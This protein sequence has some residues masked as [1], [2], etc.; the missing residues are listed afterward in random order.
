MAQEPGRH[1]AE[2]RRCDPRRRTGP[3]DFV[4]FADRPPQ[5]PRAQPGPD[6]RCAGGCRNGPGW[7]AVWRRAGALAG[8]FELVPMFGAILSVVPAVFI[9]VSMPLPTA[10]WAVL[11]FLAIQQV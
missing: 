7:T 10:V 4:V 8:L 3:G 11:F 1:L 5:V 2:V 9:A 6:H